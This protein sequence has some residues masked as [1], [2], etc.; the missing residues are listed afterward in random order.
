MIT[1]VGTTIG[2][3]V[4]T[5]A[6]APGTPAGTAAGVVG[7]GGVPAQWAGAWLALP[8][9]PRSLAWWMGRPTTVHQ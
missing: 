8:Q 6:I 1:T 4:A 7:A 9:V 3:M 5:G 2:A